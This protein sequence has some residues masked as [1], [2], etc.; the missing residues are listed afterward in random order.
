MKLTKNDIRQ[1]RAELVEVLLEDRRQA[2]R[3]GGVRTDVATP[4]GYA[5]AAPQ[6]AENNLHGGGRR[7]Q[8]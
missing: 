6:H 1:K 2:G 5:A 3:G 8:G 7:R 4:P